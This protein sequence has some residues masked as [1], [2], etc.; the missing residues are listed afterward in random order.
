[1]NTKKKPVCFKNEGKIDLLINIS[2][3]L[4]SRCLF[5]ISSSHSVMH[6]SG[7]FKTCLVQEKVC[8]QAYDWHIHIYTFCSALSPHKCMSATNWLTSNSKRKVWIITWIQSVWLVIY[9]TGRESLSV[10]VCATVS[11]ILTG[12]TIETPA[13]HSLAVWLSFHI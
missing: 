9:D 4:T 7:I 12:K 13:S 1:M 2:S 8:S 5:L 6:L 3:S 10:N 11:S